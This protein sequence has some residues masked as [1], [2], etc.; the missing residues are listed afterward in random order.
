MKLV[1]ATCQTEGC[2]LSAEPIPCGDPE[3]NIYCGGCGVEITDKVEAV[4]PSE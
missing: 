1:M 3:P 2:Q 4:I